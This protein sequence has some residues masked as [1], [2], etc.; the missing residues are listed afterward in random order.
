MAPHEHRR[1]IG[2]APLA[3]L[4]SLLLPLASSSQLRGKD[5]A[6]PKAPASVSSSLPLCPDYAGMRWVA[7][8]AE[9]AQVVSV[10]SEV[11][12]LNS[13][14]NTQF[15][16]MA[17]TLGAVGLLHDKM[18]RSYAYFSATGSAADTTLMDSG[19]EVDIT[20]L[21]APPAQHGYLSFKGLEAALELDSDDVKKAGGVAKPVGFLMKLDL[22]KEAYAW[23]GWPRSFPYTLTSHVHLPSQGVWRLLATVQGRVVTTGVTNFGGFLGGFGSFTAPLGTPG[24]KACAAPSSS[25]IAGPAWQKTATGK[26]VQLKSAAPP[27]VVAPPAWLDRTAVT[28]AAGPKAAMLPQ[29]AEAD[30]SKPA[31]LRD[32]PLPDGDNSPA[33]DAAQGLRSFGPKRHRLQDWGQRY[34]KTRVYSCVTPDLA[35]VMA[36]PG[37]YQPPPKKAPDFDAQGLCEPL[38]A[39][40]FWWSPPPVAEK[41]IEWFYNEITVEKSAPYTYFMANGFQGGYFGIQEHPGDTTHPGGKKFALFSVWDAASKVEIIE[42]GDGVKVGRFGN[43]GTGANSNLEFPWKIGEPVQFLVH[44]KVEEPTKPGGPRTTLYSG[45]IRFPELGIW[46]LMSKLRVQPCGVNIKSNGH[47]LGLNSFI[48]VFQHLPKKNTPE[49]DTYSVTRRAKYGTPWYRRKGSSKFEPFGNVTLSSTCPPKGCPSRGMDFQAVDVGDH[50]A[51]VLTVGQDVTNKG[52]PLWKPRPMRVAPAPPAVLM[53]TPLPQADNSVAGKWKAFE[54]RP[55]RS[56]GKHEQVKPWGAGP[57]ELAC[58]WYV[59]DCALPAGLAE[60]DYIR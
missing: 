16:A 36:D 50:D 1:A 52:M 43:E 7:P 14:G 18:G 60:E 24:T 34:N 15:A 55:L 11:T 17:T 59:S 38:V 25:S 40:H 54:A 49:C 20:R 56:L 51:F 3:A 46:R 29:S 26:W 32:F 2:L 19:A 31:I 23:K 45:Y 28:M 58:P 5:R 10:Y 41:D 30:K 48:E 42:W 4:A 57:D 6:T 37:Q 39:E 22:D 9:D 35:A 13:T 33:G 44:A 47:L 27:G 12:A 8:S 21:P 53:E